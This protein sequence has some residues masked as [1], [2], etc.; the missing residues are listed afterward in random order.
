[1]ELPNIQ[2]QQSRLPE[3][4]DEAE[5]ALLAV[6]APVYQAAGQLVHAIRVD[7]D[8]DPMHRRGTLVIR[9]VK[10]QRLVEYMMRAAHFF[11]FDGKVWRPTAPSPAFAQA[12]M[13]RGEW[14]LPVLSG[15]VEA[16]TLRRDGTVLSEPG[17]DPAMQVLLDTGGVEF[18]PIPESPTKAQA[19]AAL[20]ALKDIIAGFPFVED[21][22]GYSPARSVAL[23]AML[24]SVSRKAMRTA[25]GHCIDATAPE[26]G[27]TLLTDTIS[28]VATGRPVVPI[29]YGGTKAELNKRM[30]SVLMQGDPVVAIDNIDEELE[31]DELCTILTS[32]WWQNRILGESENRRVAT[33]VLLLL[34]GNN[35][36][37]KGDITTRV[38][39]CRMDAGMERPG[40]RVFDV[41]LRSYVPKH[42]PQLV[43]AALTVLRAFI[44]AGRPGLG[45]LSAFERFSDWSNLV[46]GALVWLGEADPLSTRDTVMAI[47]SEMENVTA[48]H[49]AWAEAIGVGKRVTAAEVLKVSDEYGHPA[50]ADALGAMSTS[51][52]SAKLVGKWLVALDGKI[53][54]GRCIRRHST[55]GHST[56]FWLEEISNG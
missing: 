20:G 44:V 18:P 28:V 22:W 8:G 14:R 56:K 43:A 7:D 32:E 17:Y 29:S 27:K 46:R 4:L 2:L 16:P 12:F 41:D 9:P 26:T 51:V 5:T 24:T 37:L 38:V 36:R 11:R 40:N 49:Q 53:V 21:V 6:G 10:A 23:S 19:T 33:G 54:D 45:R 30:F 13:A 15:I 55:V 31:S 50:L 39:S 42:R 1:M 47:D 3:N 34:N 52:L 48:L 35:L 25:P